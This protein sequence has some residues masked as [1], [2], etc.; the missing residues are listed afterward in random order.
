MMNKNLIK[1]V[2]I[3]FYKISIPFYT[4]VLMFFITAL[5]AVL[6]T[7]VIKKTTDNFAVIEQHKN[8]KLEAVSQQ[9]QSMQN[10]NNLQKDTIL[11]MLALTESSAN[12]LTSRQQYNIAEIIVKQASLYNIDPVLIVA[13]IQVE[14]NFKNDALSKKG[15]KGLM[16]LLPDTAKYI[17][18]KTQIK[19]SEPYNLFDIST[20]ISLGTAYMAYLLK[21]TNGNIEYALTAYNIGPANMFRAI[22]NNDIPTGYSHKVLSVYNNLLEK[23]H[24]IDMAQN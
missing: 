16:Q 20:N 10:N 4:V 13:Q 15:A 8:S 5:T 1:K 7:P 6:L 18:N 22:K 17:R 9:V 21:K 23:V 12:R 14:S 3:L 19:V 2:E 11:T 24:S